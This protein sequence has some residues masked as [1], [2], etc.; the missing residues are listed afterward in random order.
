[1]KATTT[2]TKQHTRPETAHAPRPTPTRQYLTLIF[3]TYGY[4][5]EV[6]ATSPA[7]T[8]HIS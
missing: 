2:I 3:P 5:L 7:A 8:M 1:M 4:T 6:S